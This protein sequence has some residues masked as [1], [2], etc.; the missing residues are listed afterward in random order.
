M[1]GVTVNG[2]HFKIST[3]N[4]PVSCSVQSGPLDILRQKTTIL[5]PHVNFPRVYAKV[6]KKV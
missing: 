1:E 4:L 6:T 5:V 2:N 3:I